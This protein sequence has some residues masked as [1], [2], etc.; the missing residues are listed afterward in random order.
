[1]KTNPWQKTLR[2]WVSFWPFPQE[3]KD[4]GYKGS[5]IYVG[6]VVQVEP[7]KTKK[8]ECPRAKLTV[9]GVT[10]KEMEIDTIDSHVF[11][12]PSYED[13]LKRKNT[14]GKD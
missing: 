3:Y 13:A 8:L 9:R 2:S 4:K 11:A 10:G 1:M 6:Q 12:H 5:Q 14:Y 7:I